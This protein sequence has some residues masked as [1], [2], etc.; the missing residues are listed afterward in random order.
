MSFPVAFLLV[1]L[2]LVVSARARLNAVLFGQPV[3]IPWIGVI[4]VVVALVLAVAVLVLARNLMQDGLG[5]RP[6]PRTT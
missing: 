1:F 3:S 6:R 4:A 2:G 5:L